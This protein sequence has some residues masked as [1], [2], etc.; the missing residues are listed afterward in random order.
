MAQ[1]RSRERLIEAAFALFEERGYEQT[2]VDDIAER[3]GVG[4][5]TFFRMF[6][7]KE[8]VIFPDHD[9]MLRAIAERLAG[10]SQQTALVAV[11]EAIRLV[12]RHYVAEGDLALSRYRLTRTVPALRDRENAGVRQYHNVLYRFL[13]DWLGGDPDTALRAELMAAAV[14]TTHNHV[15]RRW[16]RGET[17][18]PEAEFDA[19]MSWVI[20]LF[21]EPSGDTAVVVL[22]TTKPLDAILPALRGVLDESPVLPEGKRKDR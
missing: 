17:D 22:H 9:A 12:L 16:L 20:G 14:V 7:T 18:R 8:E 4:R 1:K 13:H 15:L 21:A 6:G 3:A 11:S 10:A 2:T 19:A 5:T